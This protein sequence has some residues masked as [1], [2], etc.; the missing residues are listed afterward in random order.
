N[1]SDAATD[2]R[3]FSL[4][5]ARDRLEDLVPSVQA[6]HLRIIP[7]HTPLN[8]ILRN[9]IMSM[10]QNGPNLTN[11]EADALV[12]PT[13]ELLAASLGKMPDT[14]ALAENTINQAVLLSVKKFIRQQLHNPALTPDMIAHY[15]GISRASLFRL[16]KPLGGIKNFIKQQRIIHARRLLNNPGNMESVKSIAYNLGFNS[17]SSFA[18]A[19]KQHFGF[20]PTET[21]DLFLETIRGRNHIQHHSPHGID[22][23]YE[24]W[25]ANLVA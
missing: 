2:Y 19:Y 7:A 18:R 15:I 16:C 21:R 14:V 22:R 20:T 25:M 10:Y 17:P 5:I 6:L 3:N 24:Y 4:F 13:A 8:A 11:S 12:Q 1:H 9:Y 23:R